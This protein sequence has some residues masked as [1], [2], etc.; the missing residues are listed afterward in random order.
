[1][2]GKVVELNGHKLS[3]AAGRDKA[4]P[5]LDGKGNPVTQP[6]G[7]PLDTIVWPCKTENFI[8]LPL[9]KGRVEIFSFQSMQC[10]GCK[11]ILANM[12][13]PQ[14]DGVRR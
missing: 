10:S 13:I 6:C 1:M 2:G 9:S 8:L 12:L 3:V 7:C 14:E 5:L 11:R 4:K